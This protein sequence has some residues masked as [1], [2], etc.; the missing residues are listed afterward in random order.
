MIR[1]L[2]A[3]ATTIWLAACLSSCV[4]PREQRLQANAA[5]FNSLPPVEQDLIRQGRISKGMD[6]QAVYL[7]LGNPQRVATGTYRNQP[8]ETWIYRGIHAVP[9]YSNWHHPY[10]LGY[11]RHGYYCNPAPSYTYISYERAVVIFVKKR[12]A[13]FELTL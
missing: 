1:R 11:H 9:N 6:T 4:S 5:T 12:V 13:A 10:Y 8:A 7:A 3:I 2:T